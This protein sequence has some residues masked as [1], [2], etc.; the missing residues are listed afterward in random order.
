MAGAR[1][2]RAFVSTTGAAR[3]R[4]V[5]DAVR[6]LRTEV[7]VRVM[8][9]VIVALIVAVCDDVIDRVIVAVSV[10]VM[11]GVRASV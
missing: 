11:D 4:K 1:A 9:A 7:I 3:Q 2:R 5:W 8:V 10:P 6:M